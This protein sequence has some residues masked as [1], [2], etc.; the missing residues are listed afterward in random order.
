MAKETKLDKQ[1]DVIIPTVKYEHKAVDVTKHNVTENELRHQALDKSEARAQEALDRRTGPTE[2]AENRYT[3]QPRPLPQKAP[4]PT[5]PQNPYVTS[6]L[7]RL[8]NMMRTAFSARRQEL[9]L[10]REQMVQDNIQL[11]LQ[12]EQPNITEQH[13]Q[14]LITHPEVV[15]DLSKDHKMT[16]QQSPEFQKQMALQFHQMTGMVPQPSQLDLINQS[17]QGENAL[18]FMQQL[19]GITNTDNI[20]KIGFQQVVQVSQHQHANVPVQGLSQ[21]PMTP[22][23]NDQIDKVFRANV[24]QKQD[25]QEFQELREMTK[26]H[27]QEERLED[28]QAFKNLKLTYQSQWKEVKEELEEYFE[29]R[30]EQREEANEDK[31]EKKEA[32]IESAEEVMEEFAERKMAQQQSMKASGK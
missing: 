29:E 3:N 28:L 14:Y 31:A 27:F 1:N 16:L 17:A 9:T 26:G 10:Q 23:A 30:F 21:A 2:Q 32:A 24:E 6:W 5:G 18:N 22:W 4:D 15:R 20:V 25:F 13:A 12:Q 8:T 11:E 19:Y 7:S